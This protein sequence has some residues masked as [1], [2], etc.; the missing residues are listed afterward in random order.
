V[1]NKIIMKNETTVCVC[2]CVDMPRLRSVYNY[3]TCIS[4]LCYKQAPARHTTLSHWFYRRLR[5]LPAAIL[6]VRTYIILCSADVCYTCLRPL[7]SHGICIICM[8]IIYI[9]YILYDYAIN[10]Y[11]DSTDGNYT[12]FDGLNIRHNTHYNICTE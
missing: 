5:D 2:V 12:V 10:R 9:T 3:I 4:L 8:C 6:Y 11:V 7:K 1:I